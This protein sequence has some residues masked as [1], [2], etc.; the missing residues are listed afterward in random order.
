MHKNQRHKIYGSLKAALSECVF[1]TSFNYCYHFY[2]ET[3]FII[4]EAM[5]KLD[6]EE[7]Q[8]R[9]GSEIGE[10]KQNGRIWESYISFL[11]FCLVRLWANFM[12][13]CLLYTY[14]RSRGPNPKCFM[15]SARRSLSWS[16]RAVIRYYYY[17]FNFLSS[18]FHFYFIFCWLIIIS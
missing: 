4:F 11:S 1:L 15:F 13:R 5:I 17:A 12:K 7:I 3:K 16:S 10:E 9:N 6:R 14:I 2:I 8:D 18:L